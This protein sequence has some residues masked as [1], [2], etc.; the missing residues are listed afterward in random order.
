[1]QI[2]KELSQLSID[3][4]SVLT[5]GVFDGVHRGHQH[6]IGHL[7]R[8]AARTN[9][10]AGVLTFRNHPASVLRPEFKPHYITSLDE[11]V[12]LLRQLGVSFVAPVTFDLELS[13]L[14]AR[15]FIALLQRHLRM[16]GLVIGPD[17]ALGHKREG[18]APA[19]TAMGK[20][21]GFSVNV[22][23]ALEE[24][25]E[26]VRSTVI[27]RA[28]AEGD[29]ARVAAMLGRSFALNGRV[30]SGAGRGR[31]LGFPT[32]NLATPPEMAI[33]GDGIYA[34]WAC[35][36]DGRYMAAT[37]IGTRPTFG[38][39]ERAIEAFLL[40][41]SGDLYG[42]DVR[43]EFVQR[44]RGQVKYDTAQALKEQVDRDVAQTRAILAA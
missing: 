39:N 33:P 3:R 4:D 10:L 41:F 40:D 35:L 27:R 36:D 2:R 34:T 7:V 37:S 9:R 38:D 25:G 43:L 42:Q 31:A 13:H 1:M 28:L 14:G 15:D 12:R 5:I 32:A 8:K 24:G 16:K 23:K 29:V 22:V 26:P 6:L 19:L 21:M 11:R 20:E 30:V 17:F 18:D 44:L